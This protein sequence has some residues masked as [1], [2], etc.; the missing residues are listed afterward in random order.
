M[1]AIADGVA[2]N[3]LEVVAPYELEVVEPEVAEVV[4]P[5]GGEV[6]D[7]VGSWAPQASDR[8]ARIIRVSSRTGGAKTGL[9][10]AL[11][12]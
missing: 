1:S 10:P 12:V 4:E 9:A 7:P 3:R 2:D 8:V 6:V 11:G 5:A